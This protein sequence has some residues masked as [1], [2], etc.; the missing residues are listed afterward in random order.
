MKSPKRIHDISMPIYNG[1]W[2]YK[3]EWQSRVETLTTTQSGDAS[4]VYRFDLCSHAGTYIETSQHKLAND[5]LLENFPI[6][7]FL[8]PCRVV[9]LSDV[10]PRERISLEKVT[11]ALD[12]S[13]WDS[14][15]QEEAWIIATGWGL[16]HRSAEYLAASPSF[17][18]E[19]SDWL[20]QRSPALL[21]VDLPAIDNRESP[22]GAVERLFTRN[23]RMLLLA[24]LV[25]DPSTVHTGLFEL[26]AV[27]LRIE[28]VSASLC[29]P[30]LIAAEQPEC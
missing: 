26:H 18:E 11:C 14:D 29:R 30:L 24:P 9:V 27:P 5:I 6:T 23:E 13:R 12:S 7:A 21:G 20:A 19:L 10:R 15:R 2:S 3:P 17:S 25:I 4:T 16:R 28:G 8:R 22:Y 1:M